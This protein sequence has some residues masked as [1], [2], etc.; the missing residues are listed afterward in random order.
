LEVRR[1]GSRKQKV[2][3]RKREAG[4]LGGQEA[5]KQ[6]KEGQKPEERSW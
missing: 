1:L 4:K 3:R 6:K 2:R 5:G